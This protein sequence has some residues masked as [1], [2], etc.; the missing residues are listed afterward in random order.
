MGADS[1]RMS[2]SK[3]SRVGLHMAAQQRS[4]DTAEA[5]RKQY[6]HEVS[7]RCQFG[8]FLDTVR[9][10]ADWCDERGIEFEWAGPMFNNTDVVG[11]AIQYARLSFFFE[12]KRDASMFKLAN[13]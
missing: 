8:S 5:L 2:T 3:I 9:S 7:V 10:C 11:N 4:Y 13:S 12:N 6:L 1:V